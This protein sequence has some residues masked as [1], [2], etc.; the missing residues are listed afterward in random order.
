MNYTDIIDSINNKNFSSIYLLHGEESYFINEISKLLE[1][2]VIKSQ[3]KSFDQ[4][5]L[6]G[7]EINIDD[8]ICDAKSFPMIDDNQLIIVKEAQGLK[9]IEKLEDYINQHQSQTILVIC[10]NG[11]K[12]RKNT[13]WYKALINNNFIVFESSKLYPNQLPS[14]LSNHLKN[15]NLLARPKVVAM[16]LEYLGNDLEKISNEI[17]KIKYLVK[18]HEISDLDIEKYIGISRKYNNFELQDRIANKDYKASLQ[19]VSYFSK[20]STDNPFIL[21]IGMLYSFFSKLLIYHTLSDK[22]KGPVSVA[23]KINP[24]FTQSYHIAS[25]NYSFEQCISIIKIIKEMDLKSK[26]VYSGFSEGSLKEM[27]FRIIHE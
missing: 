5:I 26:G 15:E 4:K 3:N 8:L 11:S 18:N 22:S 23:L 7:K 12:V 19:I 24:F 20:N 25:N 16:I 13:R 21:T 17:Q 1:K 10:Y 9:K 27:V 14:W 6:Y 2:V